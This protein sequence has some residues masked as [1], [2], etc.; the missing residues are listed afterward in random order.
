MEG[1]VVVENLPTLCTRSVLKQGQAHLQQNKSMVE[2]NQL[3][4]AMLVKARMMEM[5]SM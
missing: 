1:E 4:S 3:P 5:K 2:S